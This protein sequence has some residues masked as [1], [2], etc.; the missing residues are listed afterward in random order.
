GRIFD[1]ALALLGLPTDRQTIESLVSVYRDHQPTIALFPEAERT[2]QMLRERC[3]I[4][5][6]SDGPLFA[7]QRKIDALGLHELFAP[8]VLTDTW[9]REFWKPHGRA[10]RLIEEKTGHAGAE[11]LYVGDNPAKDFQAPRQLGWATVR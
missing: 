1:A 6:I 5:I 11:C 9:G 10:F 2:V 3:R 4:A 8:I 7:Q